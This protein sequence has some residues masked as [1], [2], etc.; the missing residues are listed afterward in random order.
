MTKKIINIVCFIHFVAICF[1]QNQDT[2][3]SIDDTITTPIVIDTT[4]IDTPIIDS[5]S[6][7]S[8]Q[9][10]V[11]SFIEDDSI[12]NIIRDIEIEF[13][14]QKVEQAADSIYF[15]VCKF[16]NTTN[17]AIQ[18]Q[19]RINI[20]KGWHLI[21]DPSME[22]T[23][24]ANDSISLPVRL[25]IPREAV[26][27]MAYVIDASF[28]AKDGYYSGA[29][30]LKIPLK[31][32]WDMYLN[33]STIYF[34]EYF[35][36]VQFSI[37]I[38]NKGNAS[39][40]INL[41]FD[42]GSLLDVLEINENK[43]DFF[44]KVPPQTD[45]IYTYT[46][47]RA[48][49][50][51]DKR[52]FYGQVWDEST[53]KIKA[54]SG[55]TNKVR[56][57]ML[58]V[59]DLDNNYIH[60]RQERS[61]PLNLE[62]NV[63]NLLSSNQPK[64][65]AGAY[66]Q[67]LFKG[68]HDLDYVFQAR[69]LLYRQNNNLNYF[70][71]PNNYTFRLKYRWSDKLV[72]ELGEIYNNTMHSLRGWGVKAAYNLSEKDE[73]SASYIIGKYYPNWSTSLLYK[74]KINNIRTWVGATYEDNQYVHYKALSPEIGAA[75]SPY[76]NHTLRLGLMGT[77]AVFDN[78]QGIG[79]P[80]DSSLL[81]FSYMASYSGVWKK[82]RFGGSTRNDQLNFIRVRPSNKINGYFRYL[83][84]AKSRINLIANY[85]A[86]STSGYIYSPYYNG[87]YNKQ[88]I[89][90][91]TY[92]NRLSNSL[93]VE[94]GPML[95]VLNRLLVQ[96]DTTAEDF[97]NYFGGLFV[98]SRIKIDE[99]QMLTPSLSAGYTYFTNHLYPD[100]TIRE[101]PA[102]NL[103]LSYVNR[104]MGASANYI[105]GP[106]FFV[107][108][109]FFENDEPINYETVQ[110]RFHHT[111]KFY[112]KNITWG[113]YLT[114]FLRLPSNRQNLV[115]STMLNFKLPYRW[116]A[117]MRANIYTNSVD[118]ETAG[119]ITH[120]NFSMNI[121][122]KKSFDVPQPRIKYYNV[123]AICFNDMNGDGERGDDE[124]LI[125]N[126]KLMLSRDQEK[127][128]NGF[129]RFGEQELVSNTQGEIKL[130]D[131]PEGSYLANFEPLFNLGNLYNAKGDDQSIEITSDMD[132]YIPYVESYQVNG[133][134]SLIRDE[135]SDKGLVNVNGVRVEATNEKGEKFAALTDQKGFYTLNVPQ[136]GYF[137]V[138]VSNVFGEGFEIDKDKFLIQFDGFKHYT[139]DFTF[140]EGKKEINFG[141]GS[142]F[143]NFKSLTATESSDS[144][145]TDAEPTA[146]EENLT[147]TAVEP[148][149]VENVAM[150]PKEDL[151]KEVE[152][153]SKENEDA[154][155]D[156]FSKE[157]IRY[158]V[159]LGMVEASNTSA[160][161][162]KL[163]ELGINS[164]PIEV[165]GVKIYA[166]VIFDNLTDANNKLEELTKV[167]F[168]EGVVIGSY[169]GKIFTKEFLKGK[170]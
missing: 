21:A 112:S 102:I 118:E 37:H 109:S 74:R 106:N 97:T 114:Y 3:V 138:Q 11:E 157:N 51:E 14:K 22:I 115:L 20:P 123:T 161:I 9:S 137:T 48:Q 148:M 53:I 47:L 78:N 86:V 105:Y 27:G 79:T 30:Y 24:E 128:D 90:R 100:F 166:S 70:D 31:T 139:V 67:I 34:N 141:D 143:F 154:N 85:N 103:G 87:S 152:V 65:N 57:D 95:R 60:N 126:I 1:G 167:G 73:V 80:Q 18:G 146:G 113:N 163:K 32:K 50:T 111:R 91:A 169:N 131:I 130:T 63:F 56:R 92:L 55:T 58:W 44:V 98:L 120:R 127:N 93:V 117:N 151:I 144:N 75:F 10:I 42:I 156:N 41:Q 101:L 134:V 108:E 89:Y 121:G 149:E 15:N 45:T 36:S 6:N 69:N 164:T 168:T 125:S 72:A 4:I 16:K 88:A 19:I 122:I 132:Y 66:G 129:V 96:N 12:K 83:L 33:N 64:I 54:I 52:Q 170:E 28:E 26:G 158:L 68:E 46:I 13:I 29:A 140:Y 81:G 107:S 82:F 59:R 145:E 147:T 62:A 124:P 77:N 160:Y 165:N 40:L 23:L 119:V 49:L 155:T 116:S 76:K 35:E 7:D 135:F 142:Q 25:S 8:T 43:K 104:N 110:A 2:L 159:E 136:A 150:Q 162:S 61:S 84:N 153:T 38:K 17:K 71:N 94:A 5:E 39:E 133:Q 99:F